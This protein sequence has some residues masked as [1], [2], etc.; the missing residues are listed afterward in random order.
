VRLFRRRSGES[1]FTR[2]FFCTDIH[3]SDDCFVKFLNAAQAYRA[4]VLVLGGDIAGKVMTPLIKRDGRWEAEVFGEV[5][6]VETER[7]LAEIEALFR[8][9]GSIPSGPRQKRW[10]CSTATVNDWR[11]CSSSS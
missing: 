6:I 4:D 5:R 11:P 1:Q 3:G 9:N 10:K 8:R 2:L 7:E